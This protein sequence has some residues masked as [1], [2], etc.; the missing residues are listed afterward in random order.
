M[1][2]FLSCALLALTCVNLFFAMASDAQS[3]R[4]SPVVV[5]EATN[6]IHANNNYQKQWLFIRLTND[7]NVEWDK[8]VGNAWERQTSIVSAER[9]AEIEQ[10]LAAIDKNILHGKMGPY[11][12]EEDASVELQIHMTVS[13][14]EVKFSVINPWLPSALPR[15]KPMPKNVRAVVCEIDRL[16]SDVANISVNELCKSGQR[17]H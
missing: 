6:T 10:T 7:G 14:A 15:H 13:Q 2:R 8:A 17:S 12:I 5:L 4:S 11:Y 1:R 9:V 3:Q 16:H